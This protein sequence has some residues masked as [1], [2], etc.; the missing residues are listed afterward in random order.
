MEVV[1]RHSLGLQKLR[2]MLGLLPRGAVDDGPARLVI[3]QVRR[4]YLVDVGKFRAAARWD[5][6]E[7]QVGAPG[8][9]V[10]H[11]QP[12]AE[13]LTEVIGDLRLNVRLGGGRQA[14]HRRHGLLSGLL[15]DEP[16]HV[17]VVRPEV[18]PPLGQA[19]S[20]VQHPGPD[21]PLVQGAAER[22]AAQLLRRDQE[23]AGVP[24]PHPVQRIG[25]LWHGQ[26]PVDGD[27]GA[28]AAGLQA[29]HLVGHQRDQR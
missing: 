15:P 18:M 21:L 3:R 8:A 10:E 12:D 25:P 24:Q 20:L 13:L 14:Q 27:A 17:A 11:L 28:D 16:A 26:Q 9:T 2:H 23:N 6:H 7:L 22:Y 29:G 1:R 4:Q 5:H 19:V